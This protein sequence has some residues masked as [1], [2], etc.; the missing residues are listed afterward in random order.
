M[1][2]KKIDDGARCPIAQERLS[3]DGD[4]LVVLELKHAFTDSTTHVLFEPE[5]FIAAT[6]GAGSASKSS[7]SEV[8]RP[9][10]AQCTRATGDRGAPQ[11]SE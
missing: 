10:R 5:D 9:I 6:R 7:F 8:P 3:L 4:A 1:P 2:T 11:A